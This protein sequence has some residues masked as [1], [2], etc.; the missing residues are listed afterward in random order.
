M[1]AKA[2]DFLSL[3]AVVLDV[4]HSSLEVQGNTDATGFLGYQIL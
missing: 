2:D 1:Q 4:L 3:L